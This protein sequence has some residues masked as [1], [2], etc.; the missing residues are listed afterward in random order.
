MKLPIAQSMVI[1]LIVASALFMENLDSTIITTA[2]PQM[3]VTFGTTPIHL[4]VGITAY[5]LSLAIFIPVS[6]WVADKFG[7]RTVFCV[8]IVVFTLGSVLCGLSNDV[9]QLA[10]ARVLQGIGGS[11]M[12]PVGRLIM[13]R[14]VAKSEFVSAMAYLTFPAL[15][16]PILGPPVGGFITDYASW[17][18]IFFINVPVGLLGLGL[19]IHFIKETHEPSPPALDWAGFF[20]TAASLACLVY[21]CDLAVG[22]DFDAIEAVILCV[23]A[24][25]A[26]W[27]AIR[28]VRRHPHPVLDP[29]L[30]AIPTFSA[31]VLGG[32]LYRVGT[33]SL[34]YM[35][36]IML[37]IG[38]G[39]TAFSSGLMI[40]GP[41]VGAFTMKLGA[42][43][44]LRRWGF[45]N[46]LFG[47]A[48]LSA[49]GVL[50]CG[51]FTETTPLSVIF[52]L[53]IIGGCSRSLQYMAL[54]S[55]AFAEIPIP[56][57]S[58]ASSFHAMLQ[59]I[60]N[61][62]GVAVAAVILN[63]ILVLRGEPS[64]DI[65]LDD[66]HL[67]LFLM[68]LLTLTSCPYFFRLDRNAGAEVSGQQFVPAPSKT[69][70]E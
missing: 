63:L 48:I 23:V 22:P 40:V 59:Q 42:I 66:M 30:L 15:V 35:L 45:R 68:G 17:R 2:L 6:G 60:S 62:M 18:W 64:S 43:P 32:T 41:A 20:L 57:M 9:P 7:A 26:G 51:F 33:A 69:A 3:A 58:A 46:V 47:N 24:L 11:M 8:A 67:T 1:P 50:V 27:A 56:R 37:Q 19:V 29:T 34:N 36:P 16:G 12:V 53:L 31:S 61:G 38:I 21:V 28:H 5:V 54:N 13:F 52:V 55:M 4:S 39:F 65:P 44:V 70:G 49:L 25:L 14:S 10:G